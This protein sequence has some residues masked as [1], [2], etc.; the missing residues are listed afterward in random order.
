MS[1]IRP[2]EHSDPIVSVVIPTIPENEYTIPE[3]LQN[4]TADQYEVV[5]VSDGSI[6]RCE[7]RNQGIRAAKGKIIA[8]TDDDCRPDTMWLQ[9]IQEAFTTNPNAVI[10]GG[11]L[12]K[13]HS[14]PHYYIGANIA[15]KRQKAINIGGFDTEF[16]GWRADTD[17]GWRMEIEYGVNRCLFDPELEVKHIGPLRTSVNRQ[18]ERKFRQRYPI[19]YFT[20]L[21]HPKIMYGKKIGYLIG[22]IYSLSPRLIE[23]SI[24][25]RNKIVG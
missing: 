2:I 3:T 13:H 15:Y 9:K 5:V 23:T 25:I 7:A 17:F 10:L 4:Q 22:G 18:L 6:N 19:R 16:S 21:Y 8:Q 11:C 12:D 20:L 24:A 14:G 1:I